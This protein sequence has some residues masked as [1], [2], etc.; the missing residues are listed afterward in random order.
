M[1]LFGLYT[2]DM[3][4]YVKS[5]GSGMDDK[6]VVSQK[7]HDQLS[8]LYTDIGILERYSSGKYED[9]LANRK[10]ELLGIIKSS[11]EV[12]KNEYLYGL[13]RGLEKKQAIKL[14]TE[15]SDNFTHD[16]IKSVDNFYPTLK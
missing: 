4:T 10:K 1:D 7:A 9:I 15:K 11:K 13:S 16:L 12:F 14:A 8:S 3:T 2:R 5:D 6:E